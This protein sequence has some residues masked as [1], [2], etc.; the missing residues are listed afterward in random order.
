M[1]N[2]VFV[3]QNI[4]VFFFSYCWSKLMWNNPCDCMSFNLCLIINS[5]EW[6]LKENKNDL[7]TISN[8]SCFFFVFIFQILTKTF[9]SAFVWTMYAWISFTKREHNLTSFAWILLSVGNVENMKIIVK[10][11][12]ISWSASKKDGYLLE[13]KKK[14]RIK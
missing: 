10:Q 1:N 5:L 11:S 13:R 2:C 7:E 14:K 6:N 12:S 4:I 9:L 3:K 8:K